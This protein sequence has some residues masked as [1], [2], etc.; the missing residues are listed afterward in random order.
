MNVRRLLTYIRK[1]DFTP[2]YTWFLGKSVW[3]LIHGDLSKSNAVRVMEENWDYLIVLDACRYD[4]F[5]EVVDAGANYVIS[6][7]THTQGWLKWNFRK[8]YKDVIYI[9]GNPHFASAHLKKT[10]GFNPF[11]MVEEVWDYGWDSN[12]KT[13]PPGQAT[14]AAL[15]TLRRYPE[16][17]MI[18]HYNQPHHPFLGDKELTERDD[19]TWHTLEEGLW[20][21]Q[22]TTVWTLARQG[23]MSIDRVEKAYRGNLKIVMKEV[24]RLKEKLPARVILTADHGDLF[25]EWGLYGHGSPLRVEGLVK[26]PWVILKDEKR[27]RMYNKLD[28]EKRRMKAK[29]VKL[30]ESGNL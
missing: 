7:G 24:D 18:V 16:K 9:A 29:I 5:R 4:T 10:L 27:Q 15:R 28:I 12:L 13:V 19:G 3:P 6:G 11:Y 21:G 26:V 25:G 8:K 2:F 14:D 20:G 22:K 30:K 17:R 1:G 23:K